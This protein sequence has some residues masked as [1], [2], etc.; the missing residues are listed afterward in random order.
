MSLCQKAVTLRRRFKSVLTKSRAPTCAQGKHKHRRGNA[1]TSPVNAMGSHRTPGDG[2][3][4]EHA[5]NK[6]RRSV[7]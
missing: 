4:F 1:V 5:Q 6:R 7:L 3:H 2:V